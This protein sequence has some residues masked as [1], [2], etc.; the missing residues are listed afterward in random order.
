VKLPVILR[1]EKLNAFLRFSEYD[2][3]HDAGTV[4]HEVAQALALKEYETFKKGQNRLYESDFD[5]I[6]KKLDKPN[7]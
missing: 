3:L 7:V 5:K 6:L 1:T 4:S 2:I